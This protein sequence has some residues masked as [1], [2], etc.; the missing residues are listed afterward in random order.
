V[1][2]DGAYDYRGDGELATSAS[3]KVILGVAVDAAGD[4]Y[5]SDF[6]GHCVRK[7]TKS[8][9]IVTTVAGT[10]FNGDGISG[11]GQSATSVSVNNPSG[12]AVDAAGNIYI[13]ENHRV[14]IVTKSDGVINGVAGTGVDGFLGD[15]GQATAA[16]LSYPSAIALDAT[17]NIYINDFRNFRFRVVTRSDGKINTFAGYGV[18]GFDGDGYL[19]T[20]AKFDGKGIAVDVIGNIYIA[21]GVNNRIR[22]VT[23]S[24]GGIVSTVVGTGVSGYSG[25]GGKA[26]LATL[27]FPTGIAVDAL[28]NIYIADTNNHCIRMVTK[29]D[30]IITTVA[31]TCGV[32]GFSGDGFPAT[33]ALLNFPSSVAVDLTGSIIISDRGNGRVRMFDLPFAP[34]S[35]PTASPT[36]SPSSEPSVS[37]T[38]LPS[39]SPSSE[40]SASP[41]ASPSSSPSSEPS[42]SPTASPSSSPSSEPS[43]SRTAS[44]TML[45]TVPCKSKSPVLLTPSPSRKPTAKCTSRPSM[46]VKNKRKPNPRKDKK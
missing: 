9:G 40:P 3:F 37:P 33:T 42:V 17:M 7:V 24:I 25:D 32:K 26:T 20:E 14:R 46:P 13:V 21:D 2:G 39:S 29:L 27:R 38:A 36:S 43:L 4:I 6:Q 28:G 31:G 41:T 18:Y 8:D 30:G 12:V 15:G 35:S 44:P 16:Q 5:I 11:D 1:A 34:S 45:Q 19:A 23:K 22:M 10:G